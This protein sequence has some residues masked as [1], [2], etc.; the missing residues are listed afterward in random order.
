MARHSA[1]DIEEDRDEAVRLD[2]W[3][4]AARFFRSRSL[5]REAIESG[6]VRY[7]GERSKVG[8]SLTPGA[9]LQIR[10][11]REEIEVTVLA[12]STVRGGAPQ[13]RMLYQET[14]R[15]QQLREQR[16]LQRQLANDLISPERPDKQQRRALQRLKR[17]G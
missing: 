16:A 11:G 17:G 1:A 2:K 9:T 13:A 7:Q 5:A 14:E 12:L 6:Q 3:L 15:S 8:R 10:Q 4:W